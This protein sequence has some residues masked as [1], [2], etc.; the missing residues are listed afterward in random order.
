MPGEPVSLRDLDGRASPSWHLQ[1]FPEDRG[2]RMR[3][4]RLAVIAENPAARALRISGLDQTAFEYLVARYGAQF[5]AIE[6]WHCERIA[7]LS[8][9]EDLPGLRVVSCTWNQRATRLWDISRTPRLT[10]LKVEDFNQLHDLDGLRG[11]TTLEELVFGDGIGAAGNG[12]KAV[13][14]SLEPLAT[15]ENLRYLAFCARIGD[16]RIQPLGRLRQL[17]ELSFP[18][19]LFTSR[20]LAWLRARLPATLKAEPLTPVVP[21]GQTLMLDG[22]PKDVQLVGK[23]KPA[24]NSVTDQARIGHVEQYWQMVEEFRQNPDLDPE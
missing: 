9:L 24:L 17:K 15:L 1:L 6:F 7:D 19:R 20:Q 4:S 5:S 14:S 22:K 10:G 23:R 21:F 3:T 13:F 8:P 16:G 11:C 2:S 12:G 18:L